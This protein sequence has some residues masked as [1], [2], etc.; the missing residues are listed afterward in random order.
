MT[1]ART[2]HPPR[3]DPRPVVKRGD[4][5]LLRAANSPASKPRPCVVVQ[6]DSALAVA[7]KLTICPLTSRLRGPAGERPFIA[8]SPENGLHVP[9]EVE[10]DWIFT[11][12]ADRVGGV[13]GRLDDATMTL[14]DQ[15]LR[16][17]LAL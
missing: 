11:Y 3:R 7:D 10:V 13:I 1:G 5:V 12:A 6:R 2:G 15:S 14:V 17:W 4:L 8:P 9:S 16:R